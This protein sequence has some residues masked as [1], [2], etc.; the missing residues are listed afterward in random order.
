MNLENAINHGGHGAHGEN[1]ISYEPLHR[2]GASIQAQKFI[3]LPRVPRG[4]KAV[5]RTKKLGLVLL[6]LAAGCQTPPE[7]GRASCRERV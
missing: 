4:S 7:I 1:S 2:A 5:F 3:G 6:L